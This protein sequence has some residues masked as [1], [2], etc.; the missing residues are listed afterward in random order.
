MNY[1][2]FDDEDIADEV[3]RAIEKDY[4]RSIARIPYFERVGFCTFEIKVVFT[5]FKIL[6]AKIKIVPFMDDMATVRVEG[7]YL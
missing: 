5:D 3:L 7:I 1:N 6:E 4:G 2:N